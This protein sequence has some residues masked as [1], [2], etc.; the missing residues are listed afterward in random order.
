M[1]SNRHPDL[2]EIIAN[3]LRASRKNMFGG[4]LPGRI[5][6]YDSTK[7]KAA[8]QLLILDEV[9]IEGGGTRKEPLPI[10]NEVPVL[11][12]ADHYGIRV[13]L[14]I[15]KGDYVTVMFAAR[16]VDRW[17]QRGGM[18][19]P[20]DDRDHDLNDA[21]AMP[22]LFDF[23]H[24]TKPTAKITFT[25]TEVQAGGSSALAL[26][27]EL[28]ALRNWAVAHVHQDPASGFTGVPTALA[29]T[30]TGTEVLKGG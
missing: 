9:A 28:V 8:I 13:E 19:D 14:T 5:E 11:T 21:I 24:V 23:A 1:G 27:D 18:V 16:S 4:W 3:A 12:F 6:S 7:N 17:L 20:G 25:A 2:S 15:Q 22:G 10:I 26:H 30:S 29:P